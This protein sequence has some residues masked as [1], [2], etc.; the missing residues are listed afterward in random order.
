M[1]LSEY[2]SDASSGATIFI[3]VQNIELF[4]NPL[5]EKRYGYGRPEIV[6]QGWGDILGVYDPFRNRFRL[7]QS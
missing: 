7:C 6:K 4:R 3:P 1:H 5:H 2:H